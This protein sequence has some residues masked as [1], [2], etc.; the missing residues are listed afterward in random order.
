MGG[1]DRDVALRVGFGNLRVFADLF[2]VVDTHVFDGTGVVAEVLNIEIDHLDP[3]F[4][5]VGNDVF[6][7]FFGDALTVL[8]HFFQADRTDD[9]AHIPFED[10][11]DQTDQFVLRFAEQRFRRAVKQRGIGRN[12]DVRNAVH[13]DVDEFDGGDG[14]AGFDVYLHHFQRKFIHALEKQNA[15]AGFSDQNTAFAPAGND[16]RGVGRRFHIAADQKNQ[17]Y[18]KQRRPYDDHREYPALHRKQ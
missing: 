9:L 16:V 2:Y 1:S 10:L 12:F 11:R 6:G 8:H 4:F 17:Q 15:P 14:F 5:H 18:G 13:V 7:D 3:E